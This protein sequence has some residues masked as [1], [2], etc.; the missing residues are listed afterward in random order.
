VQQLHVDVAVCIG[1]HRD[2]PHQRLDTRREV[3]HRVC[4][5]VLSVDA[6]REVRPRQHG[7]RGV[8]HHHCEVN[9]VPKKRF[10]ANQKRVNVKQRLV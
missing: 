4:G 9:N 6:A 5:A 1:E 8:A 3:T 7:V 10:T 2:V